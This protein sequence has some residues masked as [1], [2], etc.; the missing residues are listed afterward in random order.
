MTEKELINLLPEF[1]HNSET[2]YL[3]I[4]DLEGRYSYLNDV[5]KKRFAFMNMD[6]IGQPFSVSVHPEDVEKCNLVAY[7]CIANPE[8]IIKVQVRKP[9]NLAGDFYWTHWEFSLF[10]D[11]NQ[12][13][14]GILCLG[15]DITII[16]QQNET[17][18]QIAWQQSHEVR[19]PVANIL[20]LINI[21]QTDKTLTPKEK[22]QFLTYLFQA[23]QELDQVIHKIVA[24]SNE[25]EY[26]PIK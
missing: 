26:Q 11:Q 9:D 17:L 2:Y 6:L 3:V 7:Q 25:N 20:G 22:K 18:R 13:P 15:H 24:Q 8:K 21:I 14:I 4:T 5:F 12:Q 1:I 19:R 16:L 10:K 23:T